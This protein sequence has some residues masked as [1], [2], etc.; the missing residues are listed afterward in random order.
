[1]E[2][3]PGEIVG[4]VGE[5]GS[6]KTT[7]GRGAIGLLP[8]KSGKIEIVGTDISNADSNLLKSIRRHTGIVFQDPASSLNPRMP[9]GESIGE[10]IFLAKKAVS[11]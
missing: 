1:L 8:V 7:V 3:Y 11:N 5:S 4:L 10:P 2:I 6:G 9:I